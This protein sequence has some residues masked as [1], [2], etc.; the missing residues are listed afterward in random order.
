MDT[1]LHWLTTSSR[2]LATLQSNPGSDS[3]TVARAVPNAGANTFTIVLT[4]DAVADCS[5]AW[6]VIG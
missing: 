2:I 1:P 3:I 6:F 5:V 4:A